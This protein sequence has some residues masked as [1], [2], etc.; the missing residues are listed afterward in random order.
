MGII[1]ESSVIENDN[2]IQ[3]KYIC[4]AIEYLINICYKKMTP[5]IIIRGLDTITH[6]FIMMLYYTQHLETVYNYSK[7]AL[8]LYIEFI[9]QIT[10]DNNSF[11]QLSSKDAVIYVYKKTLY[12][13]NPTNCKKN[14]NAGRHNK[15]YL[16]VDYCKSIL[17][18]IVQQD[19]PID[20][21]K[22]K[23]YLLRTTVSGSYPNPCPSSCP[24]LLESCFA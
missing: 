21:Q 4:I 19:K 14:V 24:E 23:E 17:H 15:I 10:F 12:E 3:E 5:F 1:Y 16:F 11:L 8:Y 13:I 2:T 6:V 7:K 20:F 9:E 18:F 22:V